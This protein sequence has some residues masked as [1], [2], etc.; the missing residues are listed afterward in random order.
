MRIITIVNQKGGCGKTTA[1]INLAAVYAARGRRTLIV[2]MDPQSHCAA[3]LGVPESEL[4]CSIGDALLAAHRH[5]FQPDHLIWEVGRNLHLA[6]STVR[7]AAMEAPGGGLHSLDDRDRRLAMLLDRLTGRFDLCLVDCPP[8]IGLLTFNALRAARETLVPVETG[9]FSLRGAEKQW[10]TIQRTIAHLDRP[11]ACHMLATLH[12]PESKLSCDILSAFRRRF[13]GQII[14]VVIHEHEALREAA[15]F[16]QSVVEFAPQSEAHRDFEQLADWLDAHGQQPKLTEVEIIQHDADARE[17][18]SHPESES[19][20]Y[21]RPHAS[22]A[23]TGPAALGTRAAELARRVRDLAQQNARR[24]EALEY[25]I[26]NTLHQPAPASSSQRDRAASSP[27]AAPAGRHAST[28]RDAAPG[29]A[30]DTDAPIPQTHHAVTQRPTDTSPPACDAASRPLPP[31]ADRHAHAPG[32]SAGPPLRQTSE[33]EKN[34]DDVHTARQRL[35]AVYGARCTKQGVV[36]VQ[37]AEP[38]QKIC[39][40]GDFNNW[41]PTA[42]PLHYDAKLGVAYTIVPIPPGRYQYRLI[43]DGAWQADPHNNQQQHNEYGEPNSVLIVPQARVAGEHD[44]A[45]LERFMASPNTQT[46]VRQ[47]ESR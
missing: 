32:A 13:A 9:Y 30:H 40:A 2:D 35:R 22:P 5:D 45:P 43:L 20:P 18:A 41:S 6:P 42:T 37:P 7:L 16:G 8:T 21:A 29:T 19:S 1:A 33:A 44:D 46:A 38:E 36:F 4:E 47:H 26:K 11:I 3:G 28:D 39:V 24:G 23:S 25:R 15:S 27:Q 10:A 17:R 14:P 12:N 34:N 31:T